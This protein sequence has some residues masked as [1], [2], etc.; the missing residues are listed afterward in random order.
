MPAR[1]TQSIS[2]S[3]RSYEVR[4]KLPKSWGRGERM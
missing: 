1:L 2:N 3:C 4:E